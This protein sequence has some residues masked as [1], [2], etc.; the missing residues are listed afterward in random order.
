[1]NN[2]KA[3]QSEALR[4]Y[5]DLYLSDT[6]IRQAVERVSYVTLPDDRVEETRATWE[7]SP[8]AA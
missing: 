8:A 2:E 7:E 3:T 6:G 1:M 5:V 4:A